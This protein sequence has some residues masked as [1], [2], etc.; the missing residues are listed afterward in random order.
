[1]KL[2]HNWLGELRLNRP[3]VYIPAVIR[4]MRD[5]PYRK[6]DKFWI[7]LRNCFYANW[8]VELIDGRL[9]CS[10]CASRYGSPVDCECGYCPLGREAHG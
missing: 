4:Y 8:Q 5:Y 3:W 7:W 2:K 1:M 9:D 6:G 10:S